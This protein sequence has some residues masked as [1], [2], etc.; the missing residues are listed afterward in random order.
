M[1][2]LRI[3]DGTL[4][5]SDSSKPVVRPGNPKRERGRTSIEIA[6]PLDFR[7]RSRFGLLLPMF[8]GTTP[9]RIEFARDRRSRWRLP[10]VR[11]TKLGRFPKLSSSSTQ[12]PLNFRA[13][14]PSRATSPLKKSN[15]RSEAA[16]AARFCT[17]ICALTVRLAPC[18]YLFQRRATLSRPAPLQD[19]ARSTSSA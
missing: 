16:Q 6:T 14:R 17:G 5:S 19:S 4:T 3:A 18:R 15:H 13:E 9:D 8:D 11:W 7:P 1:G 2:D 12:Q 10:A